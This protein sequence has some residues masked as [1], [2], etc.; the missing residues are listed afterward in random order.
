MTD[1]VYVYGIVSADTAPPR[2]HAGIGDPPAKVQTLK[3]GDVA[4]LVSPIDA[5]T[6]L[7][8]KED[9]LA[10]QRLLDAVAADGPVLPLTFGAALT[11]PDAV[12]G[13]LLE[14]NRD[15][16]VRAL[17]EL[18]GR[19]EYMVTARYVQEAVLGEVLDEHPELAELRDSIAGRP[20]ELTHQDRIRLGEGINAA[21][22][23]KREHDTRALA[24]VVRPHVVQAVV[25]EPA[26][27]LDAARIAVL[28]EV[29]AEEKLT[30]SLAQVARDWHGRAEIRVRGPLA[31]YDFVTTVR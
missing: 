6:P 15:D 27:E 8:R 31:P 29:D 16:F 11:D 9:L 18:R 21:V 5:R 24:D 26:H 12:V 19:A 7:G 28:A 14:P 3:S 30:G 13:E 4:A 17:D 23:A 1:A 2:D 20:E 25:R 10:H 22:S